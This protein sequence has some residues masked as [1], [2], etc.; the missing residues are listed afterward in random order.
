MGSMK[1]SPLQLLIS[2]FGV[3]VPGGSPYM[4]RGK[5]P[6]PP[7]VLVKEP[8]FGRALCFDSNLSGNRTK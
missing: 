4:Y 5:A 2:G 7:D 3:R 8:D 6:P 1:Q